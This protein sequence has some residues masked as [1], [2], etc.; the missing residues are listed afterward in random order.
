MDPISQVL[1]Q[2]RSLGSLWDGRRAVLLSLVLHLGMVAAILF[3]PS[4][5]AQKR[6]VF[7]YVDV[8]L[9]QAPALEQSPVTRDAQTECDR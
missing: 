1:E 3:G 7:E 9:I 5:F 6:E 4:L 8:T 2:R